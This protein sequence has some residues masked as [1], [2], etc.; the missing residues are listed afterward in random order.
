M[1][2]KTKIIVDEIEYETLKDILPDN[3]DIEILFIAKTPALV[4]VEKGHYF[5]GRQ[6]TAFWNKL[7][8]YKILTV[9]SETYPDEN[10][11]EHNYGFTDI[12]K[13]PRNYGNEP[14]KK[15]YQDGLSRILEII[16]I[17]NPKIIVFVYK[18]VL[19]NILKFGFNINKKSDY[20]F[21]PKLQEL[22]N[23]KVFVFPMPGTPCNS[24]DI[25]KHM[26]DL[27][28]IIKL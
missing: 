21:N 9:K 24:N 8:E 2:Y 22:F 28:S 16:K 15:E 20:G 23:S 27:K 11:I 6:G 19:D 12:V 5:Q 10:L 17:K 3:N 18:K 13:V 1:N 4:S 14:T 26:T 7:I 25:I